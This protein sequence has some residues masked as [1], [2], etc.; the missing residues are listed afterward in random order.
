MSILEQ[1]HESSG[2][3]V[4]KVVTWR[5]PEA[6]APLFELRGS[7]VGIESNRI[8]SYPFKVRNGYSAN[9]R[10]LHVAPQYVESVGHQP[11]QLITIIRYR[12]NDG[13]DCTSQWN[14]DGPEKGL[15]VAHVANIARV[16]PKVACHK[17]EWQENHGDTYK[18]HRIA[19][20]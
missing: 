5:E 11:A 15:V 6:Q 12:E 9:V 3:F 7:A 13:H 20:P 16:H 8:I 4:R 14:N 19:F 17:I 1:L 10:N 2:L 18:H